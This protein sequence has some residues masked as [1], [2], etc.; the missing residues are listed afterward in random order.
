MISCRASDVYTS[1]FETFA[2]FSCLSNVFQRLVWAF[3][4]KW[5]T[6]VCFLVFNK[7]FFNAGNK[8]NWTNFLKQTWKQAESVC[9]PLVRRWNCPPSRRPPRIAWTQCFTSLFKEWEDLT[10]RYLIS[11]FQKIRTWWAKTLRLV[12]CFLHPWVCFPTNV[13]LAQEGSCEEVHCS[14][15]TNSINYVI[16]PEGARL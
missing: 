12:L 1:D 10:A 15:D 13:P 5:I 7:A 3:R 8:S 4:I 9:G 11:Y 2:F 14:N 6:E 16:I